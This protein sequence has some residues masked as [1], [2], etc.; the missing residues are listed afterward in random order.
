MSPPSPVCLSRPCGASIGPAAFKLP[1]LGSLGCM[2]PREGYRPSFSSQ[3]PLPSTQTLGKQASGLVPD[4]PEALS[5]SG[6]TVPS[7][8][9]RDP[10]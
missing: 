1:L 5:P 7:C 9:P 6:S 3:H 2:C 8:V 4:T 10:Q